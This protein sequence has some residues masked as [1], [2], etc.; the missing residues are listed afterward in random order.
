MLFPKIIILSYLFSAI[1]SCDNATEIQDGNEIRT[2][3]VDSQLVDCQGVGPQTCMLFKENLTD[4]WTYFYDRITGFTYESGF[5]YILKVAITTV[6]N[7]PADG[8]SLAYSLVEIIAKEKAKNTAGVQS[9]LYQEVSRG[10]YKEI[11]VNPKQI[12]KTTLRNDPQKPTLLYSKENWQ[13]ISNYCEAIQVQEIASLKAPS[14]KRAFDGAA[15]ASVHITVTDS[16]YHSA[17]FDA[18]NPPAVLKPLVNQILSLAES[19]E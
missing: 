15:H 18:G 11:T 12:S 4:E 9:V 7:P 16:T 13:K 14:E 6:P 19:I 3:Y 5:K 10:F 17:T 2:V 1:S 8:S